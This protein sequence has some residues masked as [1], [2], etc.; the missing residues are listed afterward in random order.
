MRTFTTKAM[1]RTTRQPEREAAKR[2]QEIPSQPPATEDTNKVVGGRNV[3]C[4]CKYHN[5]DNI[6]TAFAGPEKL[7]SGA[8]VKDGCKVTFHC[9]PVGY[10]RLNGP[11]EITCK[12][13]RT[14]HSTEYPQCE[15]P[16]EGK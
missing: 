8:L 6:L 9:S 13:C 16:R 12:D 7:K 5:S 1:F 14:W 11:S 10:Y 3:N 4:S 2:Q 15:A